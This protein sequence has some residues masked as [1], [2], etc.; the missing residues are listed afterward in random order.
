MGLWVELLGLRLGAQG[1]TMGWRLIGVGA[2]R[3]GSFGLAE[4]G[5]LVLALRGSYA[6]SGGGGGR[7]RSSG[8]GG[9]VRGRVRWRRLGMGVGV[10]FAL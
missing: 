2:R 1:S 6:L 4:V 7:R 3:L 9:G 8:L 5:R 10:S